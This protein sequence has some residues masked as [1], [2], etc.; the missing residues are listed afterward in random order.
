MSKFYVLTS[1]KYHSM[2]VTRWDGYW[3]GQTYNYQKECYAIV[4]QDIDKAKKY[5]S[6]K[7]ARN[8]AYKLTERVVNYE[9]LVEEHVT[10]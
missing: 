9:F 8:S 3:T 2:H 10:E 1:K 4:N 5:T 7:V 6:E